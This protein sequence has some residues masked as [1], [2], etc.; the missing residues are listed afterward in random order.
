[1]YKIFNNYT[2]IEV[3]EVIYFDV[4]V[5]VWIPRMLDAWY[6]MCEIIYFQFF[7]FTYY[8]KTFFS[9]FVIYYVVIL[10]VYICHI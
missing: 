8:W 2:F 9:F 10:F 1:M 5:L 7:S 6:F 3:Y 4:V